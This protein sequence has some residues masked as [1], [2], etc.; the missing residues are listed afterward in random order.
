MHNFKAE[1][2]KAIRL[3]K[4]T[5]QLTIIQCKFCWESWGGTIWTKW[6]N[7]KKE[8]SEHDSQTFEGG[9]TAGEGWWKRHV[10]SMVLLIEAHNTKANQ[11]CW[12]LIKLLQ[13]Q[14]GS[15]LLPAITI[16]SIL[17]EVQKA[18]TRVV[19]RIKALGRTETTEERR[20]QNDKLI[21]VPKC[22]VNKE[23]W[24]DR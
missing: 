12:N 18:V 15:C 20:V 8:V 11:L 24:F 6:Y 10:E 3:Q 7:L 4:G 22:L 21:S 9:R 14:L 2:M 23:N 1:S 16:Q 13:P 19:E 5:R 17:I